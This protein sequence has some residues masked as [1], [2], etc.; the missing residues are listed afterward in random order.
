[1]LRC[2]WIVPNVLAAS[3]IPVSEENIR[4]LHEQGVRA[5]LTLTEAPLSGF[6]TI[7]EE[8]FRELDIVAYHAPIPD[9]YAPSLP[10]AREILAFIEQMER[11]Q[12]PVLV[13][14]HAGV[15]RTG[16]ILHLYFM[17]R[18]LSLAESRKQVQRTRAQ[19][20]LLSDHQE[21]FLRGYREQGTGTEVEN[22][23]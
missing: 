9:Q 8:L 5:I 16:T 7:S 11:Q 17:G 12:R 14:C 18:G 1:M 15:G 20:I 10:Q 2:S 19:C 23:A 3:S 22:R 13:H 4:E 21:E 6:R